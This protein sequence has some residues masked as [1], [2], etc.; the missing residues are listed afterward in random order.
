MIHELGHTIGL[1]HEQSRPDRDDFVQILWDNIKAKEKS[2]F[3]KYTRAVIATHKVPYDYKSIM[4]YGPKVTR[5]YN[6][7]MLD[8][9]DI[10]SGQRQEKTRHYMTTST[11]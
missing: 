8:T 6:C 5:E 2:N 3:H 1:F 7:Y 10:Q 11:M 4:H 9:Q